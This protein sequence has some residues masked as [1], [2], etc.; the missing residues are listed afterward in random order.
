MSKPKLVMLT[1][2]D[3]TFA[4]ILA[5]T[6]VVDY[7]LVGDS[8]GMVIG[9][10]SNTLSVKL[11]DLFYHTQ[12]VS[13]GLKNSKSNK[14]PLLISDMPV[15]SYRTPEESIENAKILI[16][17]GAEMVKVEGPVHEQVRALRQQSIR[18]CGH[19]GLTPQSIQDYKVQGRSEQEAD[20]LLSEAVSLQLA[21]VELLVL[22]MI[23][24]SL[25]ERITTHIK[26]PTIGIGAGKG[27]A[28]QVLVLY[29]LLGLNP[30]FHPKFLK[31][32]TNGYAN[33]SAA[34]ENYAREVRENLFPDDAHQFH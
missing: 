5:D 19:I 16:K 1:C 10:E 23:P 24:A 18:V 13:R 32:Y 14:K 34:I 4:R 29:D 28:G 7:I 25:A 22:E 27:C 21:G 3:A 6:N 8:A 12:S 15:N 33:V 17:A 2:Y 26:I 11:Q 9:G 20:R 30:D 31:T